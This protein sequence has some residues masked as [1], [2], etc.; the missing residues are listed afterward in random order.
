MSFE[1][2]SIKT[3]E[4]KISPAN[5]DLLFKLFDNIEQKDR[6]LQQIQL[7]LQRKLK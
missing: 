3:K 2:G 1:Q 7:P 6:K 4:V 5:T